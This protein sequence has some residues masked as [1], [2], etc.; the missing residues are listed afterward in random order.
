MIEISSIFQTRFLFIEAIVD[1]SFG[2]QYIVI[3]NC[4]KS[5]LFLLLLKGVQRVFVDL[6]DQIM[7]INSVNRNCGSSK[8]GY[9]SIATST[10]KWY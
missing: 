1:F 9:E 4:H 7:N 8:L 10:E 6:V 5:S 3:V 2:S